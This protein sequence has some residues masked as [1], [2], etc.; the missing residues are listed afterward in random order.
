MVADSGLPADNIKLGGERPVLTENTS[1]TNIGCWLWSTV[2]ASGL[3][4]ISER[5]MHRRLARTV[6]TIEKMERLHGFWFNWYNTF[7][8][9]VLDAWP[10]SGAPVNHLLSTIDNAW[11]DVGLR[12]TEDAD[13]ALRGR[14][15]RLRKDIDWSFF[16]TPYDPADPVAGPGH[17]RTGFR[18]K[19]NALTP[20]ST[21]PSS[22]RPAWPGTSAWLTAPS[23]VST[24]GTCCA[25]SRPSRGRRCRRAAAG[26]PA[27]TCATSTATTSTAAASTCPAGAAH[28]SAP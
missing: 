11:L 13:P 16:Y 14:I 17:M 3:G 15:R 2:A 22:P 20:I 18:V 25:P 4:L 26:S 28:C 5:E 21:A 10:G 12:I 8:G 7:T 24:T 9:E 23:P 1:T 19:D 27:T 6:T